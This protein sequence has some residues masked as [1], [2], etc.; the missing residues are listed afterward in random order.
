MDVAALIVGIV[1]ALTGFGA[2]SAA[3]RAA[4]TADKAL[5]WQKRQDEARVTPNER[6]PAPG[7]PR[8]DRSGQRRRDDGVPAVDLG[9]AH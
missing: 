9:N 8:E 2:L 5:A 4:N 6:L 7:I 3:N 1:G